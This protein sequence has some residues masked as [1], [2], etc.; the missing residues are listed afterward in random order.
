[1]GSTGQ[2]GAALIGSGG[3]SSTDYVNTGWATDIGTSSWTISLW[4]SNLLDV[5]NIH[6]L[7]GD[8]TASS[9]RCFYNGVAPTGGDL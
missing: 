8:G 1:M 9:F 5:T 7:F 6:Y 4:L 2:F 3:S